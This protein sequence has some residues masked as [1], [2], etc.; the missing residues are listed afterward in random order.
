MAPPKGVS[1]NPNG[2]PTKDRSLTH[3]L[4]ASISKTIE[5]DG[6]KVS[7]KAIASQLVTDVVTTG[8][9]K[10]PGELEASVISVKDWLEFV[11]WFY[12]YCEPPVKKLGGHDGGAIHVVFDWGDTPSD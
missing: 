3:L 1:G 10:F 2:R 4:D 9:L 11:K 12:E 5:V 7:G 8:R 6:K